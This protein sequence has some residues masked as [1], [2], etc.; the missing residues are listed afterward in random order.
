MRQKYQKKGYW[1]V[2]VTTALKGGIGILVTFRNINKNYL[3]AGVL[4]FSGNRLMFWTAL[5][6]RFGFR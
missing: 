2:S 1:W 3:M 4:R 6:L 5:G